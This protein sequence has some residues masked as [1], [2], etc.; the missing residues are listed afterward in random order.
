VGNPAKASEEV[1]GMIF[2]QASDP[3]SDSSYAFVITYSEIGYVKDEDADGYPAVHLVG[4]A[5]KP[6]YDGKKKIL[7][8]AK[9]LKFGEEADEHTLNY[10]I[11]I[12]SLDHCI[13]RVRRMVQEEAGLEEE[14][15]GA[16]AAA[17][18]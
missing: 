14:G 17:D 15:G 9:E 8:W 6:Y 13:R 2:P 16:A 10:E 4:W 7:Y 1:I 3:F 18:K 11:R 5:Q 12:C